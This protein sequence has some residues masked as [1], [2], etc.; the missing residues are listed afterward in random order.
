MFHACNGT[1]IYRLVKNEV[2]QSW[3]KDLQALAVL[4]LFYTTV[5]FFVLGNVTFSPAVLVNTMLFPVLALTILIN[6]SQAFSALRDPQMAID[7]LMVPATHLE[8]IVAVFFV[9]GPIRIA[10][11]VLWFFASILLFTFLR[12]AFNRIAFIELGP[13][14][15]SMGPHVGMLCFKALFYQAVFV[16]GSITFTK[17]AAVITLL[18]LL[19]VFIVKKIV[20]IS[21]GV[22]SVLGSGIAGGIF[23]LTTGQTSLQSVFGGK[24]QFVSFLLTAGWIALLWVVSFWRLKEA[25]A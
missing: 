18:V 25:E 11:A 1:R 22:A 9:S 14:V 19:M 17:N 24:P 4:T 7:T 8:K 21:P 2:L 5:F 20:T 16:W 15:A 10:G 3:R 13:A 6:G 23:N 12:I